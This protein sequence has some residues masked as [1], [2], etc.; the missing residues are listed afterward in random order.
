MR[1]ATVHVYAQ[2]ALTGLSAN[3]QAECRQFVLQLDGNMDIAWR[4]LCR[5][6]SAWPGCEALEMRL[7]D[8]R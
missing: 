8:A 1:C 2:L 4:C 3:L 5:Q 6:G 7:A